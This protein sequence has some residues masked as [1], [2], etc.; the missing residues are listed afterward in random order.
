MH[1]EIHNQKLRMHI[2]LADC[3]VAQM[4]W[5]VSILL[6][7]CPLSSGKINNS[8]LLPINVTADHYLLFDF[9]TPGIL[10]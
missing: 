5:H 9:P 10:S 3:K 4:T 8:I 7:V 2:Y 1:F 6:V